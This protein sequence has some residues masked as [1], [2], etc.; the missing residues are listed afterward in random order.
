MPYGTYDHTFEGAERIS[1]F[2]RIQKFDQIILQYRDV[3]ILLFMAGLSFY[4]ESMN[5][6]TIG[7]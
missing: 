6:E 1:V 2:E 7:M 5:V 3:D 4:S